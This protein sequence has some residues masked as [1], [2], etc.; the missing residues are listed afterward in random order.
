MRDKRRRPSMIVGSSASFHMLFIIAYDIPEDGTR[1]LIA[2]ELQNWGQR[3][4]YSVFECDLNH[5][6]ARKLE[7]RLRTLV[8]GPDNIRMYPLCDGCR[9]R[10]VITGGKPVSTDASYYQV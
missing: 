2:A 7:G 5:G 4:Q 9:R 1:N 6:Q 8:S 3:V 10:I